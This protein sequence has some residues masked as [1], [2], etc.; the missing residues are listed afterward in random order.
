MIR[1]LRLVFLFLLLSSIAKAQLSSHQN[2]EVL[3]SCTR[4]ERALVPLEDGTIVNVPLRGQKTLSLLDEEQLRTKLSCDAV[5]WPKTRRRN[6]FKCMQ[7]DQSAFF[8]L[9]SD[10][11]LSPFYDSL[12]VIN[13][14][15]YVVW[16]KDQLLVFNAKNEVI[17]QFSSSDL[18]AAS[19]TPFSHCTDE[20][21]LCKLNE[22]AFYLNTQGQIFKD[23]ICENEVAQTH[24]SNGT[25]IFKKEAK[26]G[27]KDSVHTTIIEANYKRIQ[28][29]QKDRYIA[30]KQNA[31]E[32]TYGVLDSQGNVLLPFRYELIRA[33]DTG[34]KVKPKDGKYAFLDS[35]LKN[36]YN[37]EFDHLQI[38]KSALLKGKTTDGQDFFDFPFT[39][40]VAG[41]KAE[42]SMAKGI[43]AYCF[44]VLYADGRWVIYN[45]TGQELFSHQGQLKAT[46]I[47]EDIIQIR[48]KDKNT[49][50]MNMEGE[51][52]VVPANYSFLAAKFKD[53]IYQTNLENRQSDLINLKGELICANVK[54]GGLI[55]SKGYYIVTRGRT[56]ALLNQKGDI[57]IPF[58]AYR[59]HQFN[60]ENFKDYRISMG[61]M[62]YVVRLK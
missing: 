62:E 51:W 35:T 13:A 52:I 37:L 32:Y 57:L 6:C 8:S 38:F 20:L 5:E 55:S 50:L 34:L 4:M 40:S 26:L 33:Y 58:G 1:I 7:G 48:L 15:F 21:L 42:I 49:G 54:R 22:E 44:E 29:W 47:K 14:H 12:S 39:S 31:G 19:I 11:L 10:H 61:N 24:F 25:Y 36:P 59:I 60:T 17:Y 43:T 53:G 30:M 27:V 56:S 46:R 45:T 23:V 2:Y 28:L 18:P 16:E 41:T 3:D 9:A